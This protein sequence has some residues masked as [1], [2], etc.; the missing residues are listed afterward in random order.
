MT[1]AR[2]LA[3]LISDNAELADGQISVAEVVGA[4]PLASPTFTGGI[5]VTGTIDST[6]YLTAKGLRIGL[7]NNNDIYSGNNPIR[8]TA[9]SFYFKH[10]SS[11]EEFVRF[12][13]PHVVVNELGYDHDFRVESDSNTNAIFVNAGDNRVGFMSSNTSHAQATV[14]QDLALLLGSSDR[15]KNYGKFIDPRSVGDGTYAGYLLLV[16]YSN[17]T[18][19]NGAAMDGHFVASRG[20]ASAGNAMATA[21]VMVSAVYTDTRASYSASGKT[22]QY[23]KSL[24]KC[25]YGGVEYIALEFS[26]TGG[27]PGNGIYFD[28][29]SIRA[30]SN[31]LFMARDTE[32]TGVSTYRDMTT[33]TSDTTGT[34]IVNESGNSQIDFRVESDNASH[35]LF[36]DAGNEVVGVGTSSPNSAYTLAV[37]GINLSRKGIRIDTDGDTTQLSIGGNGSV[38][39]DGPGVAGGRFRI[40]HGGS[41][42][43]NEAGNPAYDF[44]VES[45]TNTH[46]IFVDASA[47]AIGMGVSNPSHSLTV[48]GNVGSRFDNDKTTLISTGYYGAFIHAAPAVPASVTTYTP[49]FEGTTSVSGQGYVSHTMLGTKRNGSASW[50]NGAFIGYGGNDS[51][52]TRE[53]VFNNSGGFSASGTKNFLIKHP[54]SDLH[55]THVLIHAAIEG[56]NAD[57]IYRGVATLSG[58]L[59][60]VNIDAESRMSDGTFVA[61]TRDAQSF[62]SNETDWTPVRG[63]VSGNTLTIEAQDNTST[64]KVSWMVVAKRNDTDIINL[65]AT[66]DSGE[67]ITERLENA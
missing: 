12:E 8:S 1:K 39:V 32:V 13:Y 4:A 53:W 14:G 28:G 40:E 49:H 63:S 29:W 51:G 61:L 21:D 62:T 35:M 18:P 31:F 30:D 26:S 7:D 10:T 54:L 42:V 23:F 44:R 55:E 46:A 56:P 2:I 16:P 43:V 17:G 24:V 5:D 36:V 38:E 6:D 67:F 57:L 41:T 60:T 34:L 52:P 37:D 47:N 3:N 20:N 48:L 65:S 27:G 58:G 33:S 25:T 59:A 45:D 9:G 15:R 50:N 22:S 11:G 66:D 19:S 64:A